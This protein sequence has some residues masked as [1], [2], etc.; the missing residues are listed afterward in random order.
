MKNAKEIMTRAILLVCLSDRC[1]LEEELIEG[2][3]YTLSER[4]KQREAI[5][6]WLD[7]TGYLNDLTKREKDFLNK[8]VGTSDKDEVLQY[9]V[10]YE[11]VE[12]CLWSLGLINRLS[13]YK[14]FVLDDFHPILQIGTGHSYER[15]K[16]NCKPREKR[17]IELQTEIAMLWHWRSRESYNPIFKEESVGTVIKRTFGEHYLEILSKMECMDVDGKDFWCGHSSFADLREE[18][19]G[20]VEVISLWRHHAFEWILRNDP[21]DKAETNT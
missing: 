11:A 4:E 15:V 14:A 21:W 16:Q 10:Q 5:R 13:G 12:P 9:Q 1:A 6:N 19:K 7:H 18:E 2:K 8:G 3:R 17:E 20:M